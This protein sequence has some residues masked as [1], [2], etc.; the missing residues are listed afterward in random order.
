MNLTDP[1][2]TDETKAREHFEATRWPNGPYCPHCGETERVYR[3]NGKS[4]RPGL[5]HCN[6]CNEA[7]TVTVGT[8]MERSH[9]PLNKWALAFRLMCSSKKGVS[10]HQLHRTL[11]VTYKTAWFMAHRIREG[12]R[13]LNPAPMGGEG[14]AVEADETYIG[15]KEKNKHRVKRTSAVGGAGKEIAFA[16]LERGGKVRSQHVPEVTAATL[17]PIL[18]AQI[19]RKSFLMTDDAGQY[20]FMGRDFARHETVNHGIEEY[21]RGEAHTN[22]VEGYFAILK[23]GITGVYHH[24]SQQHLKRYLCEF[25]FRYN[26]RM[27]LDVTD[28]Q[29]TAK[30][31]G[32]VVGKRLTYQ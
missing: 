18:V 1:I 27:A 8:V 17:R 10:A 16:L 22:T 14:K 25:D 24:V 6:G 12:M 29:R 31:I 26:E 9:V 13:D 30:A 28:A 20:R 2:Y 32:G 21:V 23:R 19:D 4:H 15:G 7:F 11:A 5:V 3:L